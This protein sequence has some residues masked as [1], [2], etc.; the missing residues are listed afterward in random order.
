MTLLIFKKKNGAQ[1]IILLSHLLC[2]TRQAL[3][4]VHTLLCDKGWC[5]NPPQ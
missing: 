2:S 1:H 4:G 3:V 5:I